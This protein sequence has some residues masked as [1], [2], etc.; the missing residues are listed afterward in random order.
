MFRFIK[1]MY[2]YVQGNLR[3]KLF[4]SN[5][6]FLIPTHIYEQI[7]VRINSMDKKCYDDGQCKLCGCNTTA[8]QM[9]NKACDKPC[10]PPMLNQS[11]WNKMKE[12]RNRR[13]VRFGV[14]FKNHNWF[15]YK[16]KFLKDELGEDKAGF[17]RS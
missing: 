2:Y 17:R 14:I 12:S 6:A 5:F 8:L 13:V 16:D 11:I 1:D 3:Y 7:C 10:Y 15:L 4:Y 9:A